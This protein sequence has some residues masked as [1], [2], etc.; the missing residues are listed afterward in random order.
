METKFLEFVA[1]IMEVEI[2]EISMET[3]YK[4]FEK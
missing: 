3:E 2:E 1:E 4:V